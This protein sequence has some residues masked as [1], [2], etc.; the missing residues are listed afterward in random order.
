MSTTSVIIEHLLAGILAL[1]AVLLAVV[2]FCGLEWIPSLPWEKYSLLITTLGLAV[3]YPLGV[4]IDEL[5]DQV[6][7][8]LHSV[9]NKGDES[10]TSEGSLF[11]LLAVKGNVFVCSYFD[12]TRG[13]LRMLR[14]T[15][16]TLPFILL[17]GALTI[18]RHGPAQSWK[19][20][21]AVELGIGGVVW[22]VTLWAAR[23][24]EKTFEKRKL[25]ALLCLSSK[26]P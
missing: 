8:I 23:M 19:S 7:R 16:F 5:S 24:A 15:A 26:E 1:F 9:G 4:A 20:W 18:I 2:G 10:K 17:A 25:E 6:S 21:L 14:S 22:L 12:Y 3:A 13:R 11:Q